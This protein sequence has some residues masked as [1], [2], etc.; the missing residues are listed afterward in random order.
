MIQDKED[1]EIEGD[2]QVFAFRGTTE[3]NQRAGN[4]VDVV[5]IY[6]P[7]GVTVAATLIGF[8]FGLAMDLTNGWDFRLA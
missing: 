3:V 5:E 6:S 4:P 8:K 2:V 7:A 1:E